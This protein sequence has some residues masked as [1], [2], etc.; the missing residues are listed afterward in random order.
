MP[1]D[2]NYDGEIWNKEAVEILKSFYWQQIGDYDMDIKDTANADRGIDT[3]LSYNLF[4]QSDTGILL[5]AKCYK[6]TTFF[7]KTNMLESW[8]ATLFDKVSKITSSEELQNLFPSTSNIVFKD[9]LIVIWFKDYKNYNA[10]KFFDLYN[11]IVVHKSSNGITRPNRIFVLEN[12]HILR[13]LSLLQHI[14]NLNNSDQTFVFH[15]PS[16][17]FGNSV[18]QK[19]VLNIEYIFSKFIL[20]ELRNKEGKIIRKVIF[21][22]GKLSMH[23]FHRLKN[24]LTKLQFLNSDTDL[25]LF[26]YNR[27]EDFRKFYPEVEKLFS[28]DLNE[29]TAKFSFM[30]MD[31]LAD[32]PSWIT[33]L[34]YK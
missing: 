33:S 28:I 13:L 26:S 15:Y 12:T 16:D 6:T 27:D 5:E 23:N 30:E 24:A 14:K 17:Y 7:A 9:G 32:L 19:T 22:F 11:N 8:I 2:Q 1:E 20:G 29:L 21:Y 34:K 18:V 25:L 3:L 10:Q 4:S 31:L